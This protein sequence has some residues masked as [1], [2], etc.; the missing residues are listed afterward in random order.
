MQ[1]P[2]ALR[3]P[4]LEDCRADLVGDASFWVASM[5]TSSYGFEARR[6]EASCE[7][8]GVCCGVARVA[9]D[10]ASEIAG[11]ATVDSRTRRLRLIASKPLFILRTL[12]ASPLPVAWLDVD[13]EFTAFPLQFTP[14]GWRGFGAPRDVVLLNYDANRTHSSCREA[15]GTA[16]CRHHAAH[17]RQLL[18]SSAVAYFNKSA[19]AEALLTAWAEAMAYNTN[20]ADDR[21]LDLL[22][23]DDGWIDRA[24]FGWLPASYLRG[25]KSSTAEVTS[26]AVIKHDGG[27]PASSE[28]N[29]AV[30][31]KLPPHEG[32]EAARGNEQLALEAVEP[33]AMTIGPIQ[34][35]LA[36]E[37]AAAALDPEALRLGEREASDLIAGEHDVEVELEGALGGGAAGDEADGP[38]GGGSASSSELRQLYRG[39]KFL[40]P[41]LDQGP[42]NQYLQFRVAIAKARALNRTL[43][44][45]LWLPHNP[46]FLHLHPGAPPE[47]SR[48]RATALLSFPFASTFDASHLA[49]FVRT[50]DLPAFRTLSDGRLDL[51]LSVG[52]SHDDDSGFRDYL[53]LSA[54]SCSRFATV[55]KPDEG[56]ERAAAAHARSFGYHSY[57]RD[58]GLRDRVFS[59]LRWSGAVLSAAERVA[60]Q[61]NLTRGDYVAAH[62]RVADAHWEHS[63]C[64]HSIRGV[65][66]RSV[67]CGDGLHAINSSSIAQEVWHAMRL[68]ERRT[69]YVATNMDCS[70]M[71]LAVI[72]RMLSTRAVRTVCAKEALWEALAVEGQADGGAT[73]AAEVQRNYFASLVE[74]EVAARAHT[75]VGSKYSTWT[76]T[77]RGMR[78]A[79]GKPA[80]AHHLFE[81]LW[82]LGV[83]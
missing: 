33:E 10:A 78:L 36:P 20:A 65:P 3:L 6:L 25:A 76:D 37:G 23:N 45:P 27:I 79:A 70:D 68:A 31:P 56:R 72:A 44:L 8:W 24:A 75:F 52:S 38:G 61:L 34:R 57:D 26:G 11:G 1:M 12:Q 17:G 32:E 82:A 60:S 4:R 46:K 18:C 50:I 42:N 51:C 43:V 30:V 41:L 83:K 28:R 54:L 40:F 62:I 63:D 73:P 9:E 64:G 7:A 13:L 48:D 81:E 66:V 77:V 69:L 74:Q 49:K 67:S 5:C 35:W 15:T 59:P 71:R 14:A 22:V 53:R 39:R 2:A 16:C 58:V 47:P 19:A 21:T 80:S 55:D 29:S